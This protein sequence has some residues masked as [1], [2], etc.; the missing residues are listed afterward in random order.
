MTVFS[1]I[2]WTRHYDPRSFDDALER[3]HMI[4]QDH[5]DFSSIKPSWYAKNLFTP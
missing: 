1:T 2:V 4:L 3:I 5:D